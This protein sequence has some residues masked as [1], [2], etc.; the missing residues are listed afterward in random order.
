MLK[1]G[2]IITRQTNYR[3]TFYWKQTHCL[4]C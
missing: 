2:G 4:A 1:T 3:L